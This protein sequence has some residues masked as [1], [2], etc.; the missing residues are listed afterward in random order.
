MSPHPRRVVYVVIDGMDT[1]AF[2]QATSSG[3]APAL[4]FIKQHG[5]YVRDSVAV[6]PTITPAAT[7]SLATGEVPSRHGIPGMCW[8]DRAEQRFVNYG[9]SPRAAVVRGMKPVVRDFLVNMNTRH[10]SPDVRTLHEQLNDLGVTTASINFLIF[11][12]PHV[13][14]LDP[15][16]V[17]KLLLNKELPPALPGPQE[18]YFSDVLSGPTNAC[19]KLLSRRGVE[20]RI[21]AT[22]GWAACVT[23]DL[24]VKDAADLILFY[25]HENDHLSHAK[26]PS[27][28]VDNLAAADGHIGYVLDALGS[29]DRTL[30]E[31]GFVVTSDHSQSPVS[32]DK[33]HI[34]DLGD[35]LE[36]FD[37]VRP[38]G[39][40]ERF[41][42][43]DV[44]VC[45]NGR[46]AFLYL[47]EDRRADLFGPVVERLRSC[48]AIDQVMWRDGDCYSVGSERGTIR[49]K[50]AD[51]SGVVD[52][53]GNK[54][55][56]EGDLPVLSGVTEED[57]IRTP[58]YP[59]AMWRIKSALDLDR[60]G[61][62]VVTMKLG[63][64]CTDLAGADHRGGGD[65]ASLHAQDSI[66][67][68]LSTLEEPPLRPASV[69]VVPHIVGHF[70]RLQSQ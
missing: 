4:S 21:K 56:F 37:Q 68:F 42:G 51:E 49:F 61:D 55:S 44:A 14:E 26:G 22:D 11:R 34:V 50:E 47:N 53:R 62:V 29:W 30:E 28:Q 32:S 36:D 12:G 66:I 70:R 9:Q 18:H 25:L 13:R 5:S 43:R 6:F 3:R 7:A 24:L 10:L 63:Y 23:R 69:D 45:G 27:S 17:H 15:G 52:G 40:K 8:Y 58:E 54:W 31:V 20:K 67:P 65:H 38:R 60:I 16:P 33:D 35:V 19:S 39:K 46:A 57:G 64:E 1:E 41:E 59:L 48:E 2:E